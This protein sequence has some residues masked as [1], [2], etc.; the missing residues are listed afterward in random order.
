MRPRHRCAV[1]LLLLVVLATGCLPRPTPVPTAV[2]S[3]TATIAATAFATPS[4]SPTEVAPLLLTLTGPLAD[5]RAELS[6]LAWDA[7]GDRLL[8]LP[9]FPDRFP[10]PR[11]SS[12][13]FVLSAADLNAAV[14]DPSR[15][16][17][18][19]P[20]PLLTSGLEDQIARFEGF[21][22]VAIAADTVYLLVEAGGSGPG[23]TSFLVSGEFSSA[24]DAITLNSASLTTNPLPV[25]YP[26]H[27]DE[28]LLLVP[29]E[30]L[31]FFETNGQYTYPDAHFH[32]FSRELEPLG[33][34]PFPPL[35]YR[36]TDVSALQ[37][38]GTF[39]GL[40]FFFPGDLEQL[41]DP[42]PLALIYGQGPT[43]ARSIQVERLVHY[44][45][46]TGAI[47]LLP[48]PP[49]QLALD[50]V[51]RNWE[52]LAILPGRGFLLATDKFPSTL[53]AFVPFP[54]GQ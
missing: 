9:Q 7:A 32:R 17:S 3:P 37:P 20:I 27:A 22:A 8:L 33:A 4:L 13:L 40:N 53:L 54:S 18:P 46:Q 2:R 39:W 28:S 29:G 38:D 43:H 21:E 36:L 50:G 35:E 12:A 10:Q 52:G 49:I 23:M 6:G 11:A 19:M 15:P 51:P 1:R 5:A 26:N 41:I 30:I 45:Y 16:L 42:E 24:R 31:S 44:R 47:S 14:A 25:A 48:E 34:A